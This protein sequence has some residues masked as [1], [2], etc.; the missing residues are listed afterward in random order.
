MRGSPFSGWELISGANQNQKNANTNIFLA[1]LRLEGSEQTKR[2]RKIFLGTILSNF[3]AR[4]AIS[5]HVRAAQSRF[6]CP[7]AERKMGLSGLREQRANRKKSFSS[8]PPGLRP[9]QQA[10][11]KAD[12]K[13]FILSRGKI[14]ERARATNKENVYFKPAV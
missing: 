7:V 3:R 1:G 12:L 10:K 14:P 8:H 4:E 2:V 5:S 6:Q 9:K 13:L 11:K